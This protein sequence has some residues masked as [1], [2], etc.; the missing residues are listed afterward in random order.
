MPTLSR[1]S[2]ASF[3]FVVMLSY[4]TYGLE[5]VVDPTLTR[6]EIIGRVAD[7]NY[8]ID[9]ISF[10]HR[11]AGSVCEDVTEDVVNE[12]MMARAA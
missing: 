9:N 1:P 6:E 2:P 4:G 10:I 11:I 7:G 5:A 8:P 12:A 3:Y